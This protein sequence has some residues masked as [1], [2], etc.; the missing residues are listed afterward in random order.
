[1]T[2]VRGTAML[3]RRGRRQPEPFVAGTLRELLPEDH[4]PIRV[5]RP[6]DL[7]RLR[8]EVEPLYR[9]VNQRR[10]GPHADCVRGAKP[11]ARSCSTVIAGLKGACKNSRLS[12]SS[13]HHAAWFP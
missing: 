12:V 7:R 11:V 2:L 6:P 5:D 9:I 3:G 13:A 1:M 4:G 8:A 10:S